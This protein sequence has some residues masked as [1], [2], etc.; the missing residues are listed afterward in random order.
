MPQ[1]LG[2][3]LI[4]AA[5]LA[6]VAV[7]AAWWRRRDGRLRTS[8]DRLTRAE[9]AALGAPA[10]TPVLL[11]FTAPGCRPC[12]AS[13]RVL[14]AVS[15]DRGGVVL[16]A[17]DV[18]SAPQVARDHRVLRA[19]TVLVVGADGRVHARTSGVPDLREL[20]ATV[21]DLMVRAA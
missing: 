15:A 13:W 11:Q 3:V 10:G 1:L 20:A 6:A 7:V 17:I 5:V 9:L 21:D 8:D 4:L 2:D 19:P 14:E 16:H 18:G 12:A